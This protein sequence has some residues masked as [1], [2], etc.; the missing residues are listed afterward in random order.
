MT[1]WT[2]TSMTVKTQE[3]GL[4]DVVYMVNWLAVDSDGVNEARMGSDIELPAPEGTFI[5]YDQLTEQQVLGWVW[6]ALG[7]ETRYAIEADLNAQ[8]VYMQI[9]PVAVLPLPWVDTTT[10]VDIPPVTMDTLEP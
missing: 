1:V 6:A 3:A 8:I 10:A 4:S 5:P 7:D 9:P 2:I